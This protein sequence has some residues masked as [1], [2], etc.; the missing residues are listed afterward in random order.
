MPIVFILILLIGN[1]NFSQP[2]NQNADIFFAPIKK[3]SEIVGVAVSAK[4]VLAID[5]KSGKILFSKN[6]DRIL[7][8]ASITKLMSVLVLLDKNLDLEKEVKIHKE[9]KRIGGRIYLGYGEVAT[10]E[11]LLNL[12]LVAS[13]NQAI[14]ALVRSAGFSEQEFIKSINEKADEI[15]MLKTEFFDP[16]GLDLR[17]VSTVKDLA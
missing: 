7:P 6:Q 11:N 9:D 13:D 2:I 5:K 10:V 4:S 15:G 14:I 17:N 8:I 16:T 12:A 3:N 1:I